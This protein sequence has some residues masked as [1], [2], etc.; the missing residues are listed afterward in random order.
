MNLSLLLLFILAWSDFL[1]FI[2]SVTIFYIFNFVTKKLK[3]SLSQPEPF[4]RVSV[5]FRLPE[6]LQI[7]SIRVKTL[8]ADREYWDWLQRFRIAVS[9]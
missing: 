8:C 1:I 3:E 9:L 4:G 2:I 5:I 6:I 7:F